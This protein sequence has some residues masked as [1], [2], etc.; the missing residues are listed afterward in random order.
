M[1]MCLEDYCTRANHFAPLPPL[2]SRRAGLIKPAMR[3]RQCFR[4]G[5]CSLTGGLPGTVH[6][7][8][9][10]LGSLPVEQATRRGKQLSRKQ[11]LLKECTEGLHCPL[12]EASRENET[13]SSDAATDL[14][15]TGP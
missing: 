3:K 1:R 9:Q 15:Q 12:I 7:D 11:I 14:G 13:G 4:L 2:I 10:K 5:Q 8:H 6:I